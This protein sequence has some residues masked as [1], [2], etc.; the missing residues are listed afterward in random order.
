MLV[1]KDNENICVDVGAYYYNKDTVEVVI[2][3]GVSGQNDVEEH[4]E[5]LLYDRKTMKL[6]S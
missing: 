1:D 4:I 3:I 6:K 5:V 2:K